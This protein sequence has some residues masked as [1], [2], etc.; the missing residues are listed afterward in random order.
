MPVS[1]PSYFPPPHTSDRIVGITAGQ[2]QT[3]NNVF[4]AGANAGKNATITDFLVIGHNS[5]SGAVTDAN[6]SGTIVFGSQSAQ[7]LQKA[8]SG[9]TSQSPV[10]LVG[11]NSIP[12]V[13][14][15]QSTVVM[16]DNIL[17]TGAGANNQSLSASV[18]LGSQIG[19]NVS[20]DGG[21]VVSTSVI[22]GFQAASRA[23]TG[24][25]QILSATIIGN[26]A[27]GAGDFAGLINGP[28]VIGFQAQ[29]NGNIDISNCVVIGTSAGATANAAHSVMVG[30]G[31]HTANA[32]TVVIGGNGA[33]MPG[34]Q[35]VLIGNASIA[36]AGR[37]NVYVGYSQTG[38]NGTCEHN[39]VIGA[40]AGANW[41]ANLSNAFLVE[42]YNASG[43]V[44]QALLYGDLANGNLCVGNSTFGTNREFG[45]SSATNILK[46]ISGTPG[47]AN[48]VGGGY[49]Y[50][51]AAAPNA[52]LHFIGASGTDTLVGPA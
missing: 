20:L 41:P 37:R 47:S 12:N 22:I 17:V 48:P 19:K 27:C 18:L 26:Q 9:G 35:G 49:F 44:K 7:A 28:V 13:Q 6:L 31:A 40:L 4:L 30:D 15:A 8:Y 1:N 21:G 29:L 32:D 24:T 2:N 45:T 11:F 43:A 39:I 14:F 46:I 10:T 34:T 36:A 3:G 42:N 33:T 50:Y 51:K 23:T 25:G 5:A 38:T 52:G 16:G